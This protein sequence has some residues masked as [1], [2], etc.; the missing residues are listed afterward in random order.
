MRLQVIADLCGSLLD[1]D[2]WV[3]DSAARIIEAAAGEL[4]ES[5][6]GKALLELL[7]RRIS[8]MEERSDA[9]MRELKRIGG[10]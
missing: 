1:P 9:A 5:E 3:H 6:L 7:R 2:Q 8:G 10:L 4:E